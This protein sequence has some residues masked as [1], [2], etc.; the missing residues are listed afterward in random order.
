MQLSPYFPAEHLMHEAEPVF[1]SVDD[2]E[3]QAKHSSSSVLFENVSTPHSSH[4]L[5]LACAWYFPGT[6]GRQDA[7][8]GLSWWKPGLQTLHLD[9]SVSSPARN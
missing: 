9:E 6:Q 8:A 7:C 2:P 4:S 3:S 5:R 1:P